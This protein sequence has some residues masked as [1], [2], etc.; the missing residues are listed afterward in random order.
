MQ[1]NNGVYKSGFA[2]TQQ[3]YDKAQQELYAALDAVEARLT[4]HRFLLGDRCESVQVSCLRGICKGHKRADSTEAVSGATT[5]HCNAMLT[6]SS[7]F[8]TT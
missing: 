2:T 1:I 5:M 8:C 4:Q 7:M 6:I 3:A